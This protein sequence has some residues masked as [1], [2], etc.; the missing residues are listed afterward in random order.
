MTVLLTNTPRMRRYH[1]GQEPRRVLQLV[2][3]GAR[4]RPVSGIKAPVRD[5]A[6]P[7]VYRQVR[8]ALG[9]SRVVIASVHTVGREASSSATSLPTIPAGATSFSVH[10]RAISSPST[11][12]VTTWPAPPNARW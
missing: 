6:G 7:A 9:R 4:H 3:L 12:R 8:K 2:L 1:Y 10:G 5:R 11:S